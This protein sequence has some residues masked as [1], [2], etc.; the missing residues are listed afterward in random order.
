MKYPNTQW[1]RNLKIYKFWM[2]YQDIF[3]MNDIGKIQNPKISGARVQQIVRNPKYKNYLEV[4][5]ENQNKIQNTNS[6]RIAQSG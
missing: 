4:Q 6:K 5:N 2:E 1:D 3:T